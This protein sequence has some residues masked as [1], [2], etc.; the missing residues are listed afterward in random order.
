[1][2]LFGEQHEA[3]GSVKQEG[4][5]GPEWGARR[6]T[7]RSALRL[8]GGASLAAALAPY[9]PA[10]R[11]L[12]QAGA[13]PGPTGAIVLPRGREVV[14]V[15]ADGS[16]ERIVAE[17]PAGEFVADA[18]LSPDGT[19]VAFGRFGV[20]AGGGT[21]GAD[22]MLAPIDGGE[23]ARMIAERDAPGTLL[24]AP[25][26]APDGRAILFE[27]IGITR[28]GT[29]TVRTDLVG[30]D[31]GGRRTVA[32]DAR[33]PTV[34]ADGRTLAYVRSTLNG[35]A[36]WVQP[37]DG[38]AGRQVLSEQDL[39][40]VAYPR[41]APDGTTLLL[42]GVGDW[43]RSPLKTRAGEAP[44]SSVPLGPDRLRAVAAHGLPVDPWLVG[45]DGA[46]LRRMALL[47]IDDAAVAWSPDGR[48][49]AVSGAEGVFVLA[50]ADPTTP[51]KISESSS[52]GAIDWR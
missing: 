1:V 51:T 8:A 7:R 28:S 33:Y 50:A 6:L 35:D 3:G 43:A 26:F 31:G 29:P 2:R 13:T 38:G 22:L 14:L 5:V 16:G 19:R 32:E 15:R 25:C 23:P 36:L 45:A 21:G 39:L 40:I 34:S 11:A 18:A 49:A 27:V 12:A 10:A 44:W 9:R 24:A 52:F 41:F 4:S 37:F 20:P 47:S 48:W 42:A 30:L 46:N 17:L